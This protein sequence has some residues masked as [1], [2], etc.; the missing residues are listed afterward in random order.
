MLNF[1]FLV[2]IGIFKNLCFATLC[3]FTSQMI[4]TYSC[5]CFCKHH[6]DTNCSLCKEGIEY[7][8]VMYINVLEPHW[9]VCALPDFW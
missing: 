5:H 9:Q 3:N 2:L 8:T 4:L 6:L 7:C 1:E